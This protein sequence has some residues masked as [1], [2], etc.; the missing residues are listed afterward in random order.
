MSFPRGARLLVLLGLGTVACENE[1]A[2][3]SDSGNGPRVGDAGIRGLLI[4]QSWD[5]VHLTSGEGA[6]NY[7]VISLQEAMYTLLPA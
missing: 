7:R 3:E 1:S 6:G 4:A 5:H 2:S